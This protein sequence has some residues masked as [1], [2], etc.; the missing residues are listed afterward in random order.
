[1]FSN[2]MHGKQEWFVELPMFVYKF[3][4]SY[5]VSLA[6]STLRG[7]ENDLNCSSTG[8]SYSKLSI[9]KDSSMP[10]GNVIVYEK[11][12]CGD[13]LKILN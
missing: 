4:A 5:S 8:H 10:L 6:V 2:V 7:G 1:M 12:S 3:Q 9:T 11:G 13:L